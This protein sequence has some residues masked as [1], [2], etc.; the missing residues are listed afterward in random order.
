MKKYIL[1]FILSYISFGIAILFIVIHLVTN[2]YHGTKGFLT[3]EL[4][5]VSLAL[6]AAMVFLILAINSRLTYRLS[7][8]SK[9]D[10]AIR[11]LKASTKR[12]EASIRAACKNMDLDGIA[13]EITVKGIPNKNELLIP[14]TPTP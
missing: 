3:P 13:V 11:E 5:I 6:V 4:G 8:Q 2:I 7:R 9:A 1:L 10:K 14:K 12:A